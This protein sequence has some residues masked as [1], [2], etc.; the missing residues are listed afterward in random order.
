MEDVRLRMIVA[1]EWRISGSGKKLAM[2]VW[3]YKGLL[4]LAPSLKTPGRNCSI[5]H[6]K[7]H[8]YPRYLPGWDYSF[9]ILVFSQG[10][11]TSW[12]SKSEKAVF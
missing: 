12:A 2:C 5:L 11:P 6:A 7:K 1:G 4:K 9:L 3:K 10:D 8:L